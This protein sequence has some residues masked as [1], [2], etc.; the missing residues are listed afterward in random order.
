MACQ[1]GLDQSAR[2]V[3]RDCRCRG[4]GNARLQSRRRR[5]CEPLLRYDGSLL[6][7]STELPL[8][9]NYAALAVGDPRLLPATIQALESAAWLS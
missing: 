1:A 5:R 8:D 2:F 3:V 7:G 9:V 6:D 4:D